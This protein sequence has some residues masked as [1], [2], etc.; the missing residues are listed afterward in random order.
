[1]RKRERKTEIKLFFYSFLRNTR[2]TIIVYHLVDWSNSYI[3]DAATWKIHQSRLTQSKVINRT[4][5]EKRLGERALILARAA[6][7]PF[8]S[9]R[10][11]ESRHAMRFDARYRRQIHNSHA[12]LAR[13]QI[14]RNQSS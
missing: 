10:W 4:I 13:F 3:C 12:I 14:R 8:H 1:M 2:N 9:Y 6:F 7:L 5:T 11:A